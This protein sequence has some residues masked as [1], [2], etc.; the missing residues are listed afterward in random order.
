MSR[1][2]EVALGE[3]D[4]ED[5]LHAWNSKVVPNRDGCAVSD[6]KHMLF[7]TV[8]LHHLRPFQIGDAQERLEVLRKL[9]YFA[10]K[11]L[12]ARLLF[13]VVKAHAVLDSIA[14]FE[15]SAL[16]KPRPPIAFAWQME[17]PLFGA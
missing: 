8:S 13:V 14:L 4:L 3:V 5:I 6:K 7:W 17:S 11:A 2:F 10:L 12:P 9:P 1:V 15:S 16:R